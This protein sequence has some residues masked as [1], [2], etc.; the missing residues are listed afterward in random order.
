MVTFR[1]IGEMKKAEEALR[2]SEDQ[3]RQ[4][5]K[6]GVVGQLAGGVAHDFNNILTVILGYGDMVTGACYPTGTRRS[7]SS[8]RF[9]RPANGRR[10]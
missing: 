6:M 5:Q 1:D 2:R 8:P 3:L 4:A 10:P 7:S 9:S